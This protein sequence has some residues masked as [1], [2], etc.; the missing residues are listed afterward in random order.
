MEGGVEEKR[1]GGR[2]EGFSESPGTPLPAVS[3]TRST[4]QPPRT[5]V[6]TPAALPQGRLGGAHVIPSGPRR[7]LSLTPFT[8][9]SSPRSNTHIHT[10]RNAQTKLTHS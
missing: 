8:L 5:S 4:L 7:P 10:L 6:S 9:L 2:V 3:H 1:Q